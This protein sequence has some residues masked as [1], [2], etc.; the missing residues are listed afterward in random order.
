MPLMTLPP[1]GRSGGEGEG[2][3]GDFWSLEVSS[4]PG[5]RGAERGR[6]G[7][8]GRK[9]LNTGAK[10]HRRR[11]HARHTRP[12]GW[13]EEGRGVAPRAIERGMRKIRGAQWLG[14]VGLG[15]ALA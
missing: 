10:R 11:T 13:R 8:I 14:L 9:R 3:V 6:R 4:R 7:G 2:R 12:S 15:R 1:S 5:R